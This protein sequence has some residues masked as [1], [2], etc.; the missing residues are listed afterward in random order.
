MIGLKALAGLP[1]NLVAL[2]AERDIY[3]AARGSDIRIAPHLHCT[4]ADMDRLT[5]ALATLYDE[6]LTPH[7]QDVRFGT[8]P[9]RPIFWPGR[10]FVAPFITLPVRAAR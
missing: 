10:N 1:D 6:A 3:V 4:A 7:G 5:A 2:L 9:V 8:M